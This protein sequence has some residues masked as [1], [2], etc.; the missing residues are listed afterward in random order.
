MK[1]LL[2]IF[3]FPILVFSQ[4]TINSPKLSVISL[5]KVK[6]VYRGVDNPI[7][8]AVPN[9]KEYSV[10]GTSVS[11]K[12][13]GSYILRPGLGLETKVY[14]EI[15]LQDDSV[16]I[17]EHVYQIKSIPIPSITIND[18]FSTQG[19][20]EFSLDE[21]KDAEVGLKI[22]DFLF[23]YQQDVKQF[24]IKVGNYPT[25]LVKGNL[26]TD[27]VFNLLKKAKKKDYIILSNIKG[28]F[29]ASNQMCIRIGTLVFR[30]VEKYNPK[31]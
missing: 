26:F 11:L 21:L 5:D 25:L 8:V 4:D 28:S 19:Y 1:K 16:V 9:A 18:E 27:D 15:I 2:F 24:T 22:L 14:I 3:L 20:L 29:S 17:E 31:E 13:D 10:S 30:I 7:T 6:V 12:D 23:P